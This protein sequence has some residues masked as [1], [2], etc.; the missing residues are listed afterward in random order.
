MHEKKWIKLWIIITTIPLTFVGLIN[1]IVDP[2]WTFDHKNILNSKQLHFNER[3]QKSNNVY[4]NGLDNFDGLL[5][6]S[7]RSTFINQNEF[8]NMN[9][10]NYAIDSMQAFEYID[11]LN[12][13]KEIKG[14]EFKY[15]IIGADFYNTNDPSGK[16]LRFEEPSHYIQNSKEL[17]YRYKMIFSIDLLK[18][19]LKNIKANFV[20]PG[21]YYSSDNIKYRHKVSEYDRLNAY[22]KNIIRHTKLF[23]GKNYT[24]NDKYFNMLKQMKKDNPSTQF[25]IFTSPVTAD[26][27]VSILRNTKKYN[28]Y[29]DWI[30]GLVDTFDEIYCFM[31]VNSV[32]INHKNYPDDDHYYPSV[33]KILANKIS[34]KNFNIEPKDFGVIVNHSNVNSFL[35]NQLKR[36]NSYTFTS[37]YPKKQLEEELNGK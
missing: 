33:A 16:D 6:G 2:L 28:E 19:S 3:Q 25:I 7:S 13:A 30:K 26:L 12:F 36:I 17:M 29:Q 11:Y 34:T 18:K 20:E 22:T 10:Y 5:F 15:I 27:F 24:W 8:I 21:I 32:T 31:D 35:K 23:Y 4:F 37:S 14:R 1:Y 9:I